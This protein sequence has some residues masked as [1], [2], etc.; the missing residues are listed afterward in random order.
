MTQ[1]ECIRAI[2]EIKGSPD[3]LVFKEGKRI[4]HKG[5]STLIQPDFSSYILESPHGTAHLR[6][7][8]I[9]DENM[10]SRVVEYEWNPK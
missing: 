8:V 10:E 4:L 5:E 3:K 2:K 7:S 9:L 6:F 1:L